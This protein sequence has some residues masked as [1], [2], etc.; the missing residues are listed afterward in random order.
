MIKNTLTSFR[1]VMLTIG[2]LSGSSNV[3]SQVPFQKNDVLIKISPLSIVNPDLPVVEV[4]ISYFI[5]DRTALQ[6]KYGKKV[7]FLNGKN[8]GLFQ[9]QSEAVRY[10]GYKLLMELRHFV[11]RRFYGA[12]EIGYSHDLHSDTMGYE[13]DTILVVDEFTI[14]RHRT[15]FT[16]KVGFILYRMPHFVI[17]VYAGLGLKHLRKFVTELE[18]DESAGHE[19]GDPVDNSF[20][21]WYGPT[22]KPYE[23]TS[24]RISLGINL[25]YRFGR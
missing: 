7:D 13:D 18:F 16:G 4:G 2:L 5:S 15:F 3:L 6:F 20:Y 22:Y 19:S 21:E 23:G 8:G 9:N 11:S 10:N 17:D 14:G 25:N 1:T 24:L 12:F